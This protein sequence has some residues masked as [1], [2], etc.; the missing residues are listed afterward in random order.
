[1]G[2][3]LQARGPEPQP[4]EGCRGRVAH[5]GPLNG[6]SKPAPREE[7]T[8]RPRAAEPHAAGRP[9]F[10]EQTRTG[11]HHTGNR[12]VLYPQT[13]IRRPWGATRSPMGAPRGG[14]F[15][16]TSPPPAPPPDGAAGCRRNCKPASALEYRQ[17]RQDTSN[18]QPRITLANT[19]LNQKTIFS[20]SGKNSGHNC[21][22]GLPVKRSELGLPVEL[23][24]RP[25]NV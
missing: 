24:M 25:R 3:W 6:M 2:H 18:I 12:R 17:G 23:P 4:A 9:T 21:L 15:S 1:M 11:K 14:A 16:V 8:R 20:A 22:V 10:H 13:H 19:E 7:A 5:R